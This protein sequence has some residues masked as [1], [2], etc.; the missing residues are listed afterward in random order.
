LVLIVA[1]ATVFIVIKMESRSPS[2]RPTPSQPVTTAGSPSTAPS[3]V[4]APDRPMPTLPPAGSTA[5]SPAP[6]PVTPATSAATTRPPS[7]PPDVLAVVAHFKDTSVPIED[8]QNEVAALAK[9]GDGEAAQI[10][11][12]LGSEYT[13]LN[14][15][16]VEGLANI[17]DPA[18]APYL[19][20]RLQDKD[21]R[22][23]AAAVKSLA[24][25][26]GEGAVA[27]IAKVIVS[28][29][30]REDGY[31]DTVCGACV[32]ALAT[33]RSP[34]AIPILGAELAETV[35]FTLQ[36]DY[37]SRV[38]QALKTINDPAAKPFLQA[39]VDK[40]TKQ[41]DGMAENPMGQVYLKGKIDEAMQV[42]QGLGSKTPTAP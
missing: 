3:R 27:D 11:M 38:V 7:Y 23:L 16:A 9:K 40:L 37:G 39:Y 22:I 34:Q 5:L 32:D 33:T 10:L 29:R 2:P 13:Y 4:D 17:K 41:M 36:H 25:Q 21:H 28:N 12:A 15:M 42:A 24:A 20:D 19:K 14:F 18:I 1:L 31:Q 30:K 6:A 26:I 8:R 35:G